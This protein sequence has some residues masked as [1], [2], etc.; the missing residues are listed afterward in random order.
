MAAPDQ[1]PGEMTDD[2]KAVYDRVMAAVRAAHAAHGDDVAA[3]A[4]TLDVT[5]KNHV[6]D[7]ASTSV[8]APAAS[9]ASAVAFMM[10]SG[11]VLRLA[12]ITNSTPFARPCQFL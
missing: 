8:S 4:K 6:H 9:G 3:L 10:S 11:C 2:E 12:D 1:Q 5:A 7:Q